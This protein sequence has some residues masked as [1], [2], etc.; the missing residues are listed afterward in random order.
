MT[1]HSIAP[2]RL[3]FGLV[4]APLAWIVQGLC[5][6]LFGSRVCTQMSIG[7][8]RTVLGV[9]SVVAIAT[10]LGGIVVG[11]ANWRTATREQIAAEDRVEFMSLGGLLVSSVFLL[12]IFWASLNAVFV[13]VCGGIR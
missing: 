10:A 5:G 2:R 3:W 13:N 12:G 11:L 4:A 1:T 7:G 6:W 9:L 8:A